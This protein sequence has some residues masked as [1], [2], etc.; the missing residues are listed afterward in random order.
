VW[1]VW[2]GKGGGRRRSGVD[3]PAARALIRFFGGQEMGRSI[4]LVALL[5][6]A[7]CFCS[8]PRVEEEYLVEAYVLAIRARE[9]GKSEEDVQAAVDA[10]LDQKGLTRERLA[11]LTKQ[12]DERPE[13]WAG[14]W[15]RIDER[16]RAAPE[17]SPT[18]SRGGPTPGS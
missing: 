9:S 12:L 13:A 4:T 18:E 14:I 3:E 10:W 5:V 2:W 11:R 7:A 17:I 15:S 6:S 8:G 1:I 16:L